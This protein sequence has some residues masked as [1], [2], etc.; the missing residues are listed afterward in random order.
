M[1]QKKED[2]PKD[3]SPAKPKAEKATSDDKVK[4]G[5][6]I[7]IDYVGSLEDGTVFDSS[8]RHGQPL[9]FQV[10]CGQVIKGFEDAMKGMK[11]GESKKIKIQ[12]EDAYGAPDERLVK[13]F[14]KDQL[15]KE[16]EPK[17]GM[18]LTVGTP[19]GRTMFAQIKDV[20]ETEVTID[21]NHPL[22]GKVL[23]FEVKVID[24]KC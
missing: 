15:P 11:K 10:G 2:K 14:P 7:T 9:E 5:D 12:P 24:I 6:T 8:E 16:P 23:N 3:E 21:L 13:K 4:D 1:P 20:S 18:V 22:A 19:D 17:E